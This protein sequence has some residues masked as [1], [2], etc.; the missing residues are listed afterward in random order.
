MPSK[1]YF[2]M[3]LAEEKMWW[4]VG[5]R[6]LL[7]RYVK[8]FAKSKSVILDAG[9]GTGKNMEMLLNEGYIV[10]GIDFSDDALKY[11]R[12][13]GIRSVKKASVSEMPFRN[14]SFDMVISMDVLGI[15]KNSKDVQKTIDECWRILKP[16]GHLILQCAA[17]P[18]LH[19]QHDENI[20]FKKRFY[21]RELESYFDNKKWVIKKSSYRT[22]FMFAIVAIVKIFKKAYLSSK[23]QKSTFIIP[24]GILNWIFLQAQLIENDFFQY[25]NFPIGT[26]IF[27]VAQKK[28]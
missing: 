3:Y 5:L 24:P 10:K 14:K 21:K 15:F 25:I 11:S 26:S 1:E 12:M 6:D 22:F 20:S 13:R 17:L 18:W 8:K 23:K 9:C 16:N 2:A 27:I 7:L 19:S 4:Y 28:K